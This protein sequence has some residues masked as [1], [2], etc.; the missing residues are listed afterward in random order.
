MGH[1]QALASKARSH[2]LKRQEQLFIG[3][4]EGVGDCGHASGR[5]EQPAHS[6]PT[7]LLHSLHTTHGRQRKV[8]CIMPCCIN[9]YSNTCI[10]NVYKRVCHAV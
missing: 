7:L 2:L 9:V 3:R 4:L 6:S 5:T 10:L 1:L 8:C